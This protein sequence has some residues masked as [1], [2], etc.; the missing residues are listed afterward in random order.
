MKRLTK[1]VLITMLAGG[2]SI[3]PLVEKIKV[4][5]IATVAVTQAKMN[6]TQKQ[7]K[8]KLISVLKK[9]KM[10]YKKKRN[11]EGTSVY[12]HHFVYDHKQGNKYI[13]HYYETVYYNGVKDHIATFGWYSINKKTGKIQNEVTFEKL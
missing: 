9:K 10:F 5:G 2:L 4:P 6:L 13:F 7:A 1:Y 8:K 12:M 11:V 3:S